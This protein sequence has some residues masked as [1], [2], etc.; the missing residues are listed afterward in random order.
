[1][2]Q[3][4]SEEGLLGKID[5]IFM[6][7]GVSSPQLDNAER[8]FSCGINRSIQRKSPTMGKQL[9]SFFTCVRE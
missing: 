6:D 2:H 9:V 5:G 8:G 4:L 1:M 7:L 3:I